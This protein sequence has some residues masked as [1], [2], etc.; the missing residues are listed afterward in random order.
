[1]IHIPPGYIPSG[2]YS[3]MSMFPQVYVLPG[4]YSPRFKFPYDIS[5]VAKTAF[6]WSLV[7]KILGGTRLSEGPLSQKAR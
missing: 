7:G 5:S 6:D 3:P 4:L 2:L 1:M